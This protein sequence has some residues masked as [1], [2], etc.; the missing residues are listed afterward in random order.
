M[1]THLEAQLGH[2][3]YLDTNIYI[4]GFEGF[5]E[6]RHHLLPLLDY[7]ARLDVDVVGSEL[8]IPELLTKP[9]ALDDQELIDRYLDFFDAPDTCQ[10]VPI[11]RPVLDLAAELRGD[12]GLALA[13]AIHLATALD[14][15]CTSFVTADEQLAAFD[16]LPVVTLSMLACT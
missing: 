14:Q 13:D 1:S 12:E 3:L 2:S 6:H 7:A 15:G 11:S 5:G 16:D 10:L 8:L 4:Y 9:M